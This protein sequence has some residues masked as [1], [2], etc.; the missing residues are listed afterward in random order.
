M[1]IDARTSFLQGRI[2]PAGRKSVEELK[3]IIDYAHVPFYC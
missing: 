1:D 3:E 2:P